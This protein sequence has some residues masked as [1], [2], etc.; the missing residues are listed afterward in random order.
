[1]DVGDGQTQLRKRTYDD[2]HN[3]ETKSTI[4][5]SRVYSRERIRRDSS[6]TSTYWAVMCT[7]QY[8]R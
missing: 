3:T 7:V 5:R 2:V 1:M 4:C 6:V 8:T